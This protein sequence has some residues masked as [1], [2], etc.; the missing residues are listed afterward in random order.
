MAGVFVVFAFVV[1]WLKIVAG[2]FVIYINVVSQFA[3]SGLD[4]EDIMMVTV[5]AIHAVDRGM[6]GFFK[7]M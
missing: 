6:T 4:L 5:E 1:K 3:F 2:L 7:M